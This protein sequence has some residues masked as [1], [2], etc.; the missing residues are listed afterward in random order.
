MIA[1]DHAFSTRAP[2]ASF[3]YYQPLLLRSFTLHQLDI[4]T[5]SQPL[6]KIILESTL[7][8]ATTQ[9]A[10]HSEYPYV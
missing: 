6:Q 9:R 1:T 4:P 2:C 10:S 8:L 7:C 3:L 5:P